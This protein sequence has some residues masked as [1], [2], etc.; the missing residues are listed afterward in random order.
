MAG[1]AAHLNAVLAQPP[2]QLV[3]KQHVGLRAGGEGG[4]DTA[5]GKASALQSLL[6]IA[7]PGPGL[8]ARAAA[9]PMAP[10]VPSAPKRTAPAAGPTLSS[11]SSTALVSALPPALCSFST[12]NQPSTISVP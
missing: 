11:L 9:G 1:R 10:S 12:W 5:A 6:A 8:A 2:L 7:V 3:G 4:G